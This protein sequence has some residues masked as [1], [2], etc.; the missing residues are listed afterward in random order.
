MR[1]N[2]S[3]YDKINDAYDLK[4]PKEDFYIK[5]LKESISQIFSLSTDLESI[6]MK[7]RQ[8]GKIQNQAKESTE[9]NH[10]SNL[11]LVISHNEN[12]L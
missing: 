6:N 7:L 12:S 2:I 5:H 11:N 10:S 3:F 4:E 1:Y 9:V 8:D